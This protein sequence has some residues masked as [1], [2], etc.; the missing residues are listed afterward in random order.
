MSF[1]EILEENGIKADEDGFHAC[2][3]VIRILVAVFL[4]ARY[5]YRIDRLRNIEKQ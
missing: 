2:T 5:V 3:T 1:I 4:R